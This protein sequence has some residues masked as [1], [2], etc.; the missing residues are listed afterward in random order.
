MIKILLTMLVLM[1][2]SLCFAQ[3]PAEKTVEGITVNKEEVEKSLDSLV[4]MG[5]IT[6]ADAKV[7]KEQ[8]RQMS[9]EDFNKLVGKGKQEAK[10]EIKKDG[11][12][13]GTTPTP[14]KK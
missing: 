2:F 13:S 12:A 3:S 10:K 8:L 6:E 9:K 11:S 4:K 1:S 7:A 5:T 14:V